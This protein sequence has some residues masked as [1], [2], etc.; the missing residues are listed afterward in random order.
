[1]IT[2]VPILLMDDVNY[3]CAR[4]C[5]K[6]RMMKADL[7]RTEQAVILSIIQRKYRLLWEHLK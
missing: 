6:D 7:G 2:I 4:H 3:L 1:M 5:A